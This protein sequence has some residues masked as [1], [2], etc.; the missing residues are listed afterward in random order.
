[1]SL[2]ST[3]AR[4]VSLTQ[5]LRRDWEDTKQAWHDE[6]SAAFEQRY[7]AELFAAVDRAGTALESLDRLLQKV[8]SECE[9]DSRHP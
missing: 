4:L 1:M 5:N 7:L 3:R 6:R 8:K 9:Q 2:L